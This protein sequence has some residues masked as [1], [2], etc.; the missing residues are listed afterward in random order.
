M[1]AAL[2]DGTAASARLSSRPEGMVDVILCP[3]GLG[4]APKIITAKWWGYTSQWSLLDYPALVFP[5]D[6]VGAEKDRAGESS[7]HLPR[8]EKDKFDWELWE[9]HGAGGHK[10]TPVSLQLVGRRLVLHL[11]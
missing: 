7:T 6:K 9:S 1:Y 5:V 8:N 3:A 11:I 10:D 2:R 4:A